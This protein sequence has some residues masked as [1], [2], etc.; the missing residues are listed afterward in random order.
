MNF[1]LAPFL[2]MRVNGLTWKIKFTNNTNDL[3]IGNRIHLG[4]TDRDSRTVFLDDSLRNR[5]LRKVLIHELT[6]VWAYSYGYNI[7]REDEEFL[8][9]FIDTYA[10]EIINNADE[11]LKSDKSEL[12]KYML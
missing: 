3:R 7:D 2:F 8:C 1:M 9:S 12:K 11:F 4:V 5:L 10:E 6:H